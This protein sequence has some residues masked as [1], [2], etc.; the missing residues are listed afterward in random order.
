MKKPGL[1]ITFEGIEGVGKSTQL[2]LAAQWLRERGLPVR[3]T[4]EPGG[5]AAGEA[6]RAILLD[7]RT[8]ALCPRAELLMIFAA[9]A[10]HLDKVV[11]PA[12]AAG[13]LVLCDRFTDATYAYQGGGRGL[14]PA[15]IATLETLVQ[16]SLRPDVTLLLDAPPELG[17]ARS[18]RR[19]DADR[20]EGE[21]LA[22]FSAVRACYL[23]R[24][25]AEPGRFRLIDAS[26]PLDRVSA[27]V[28]EALQAAVEALA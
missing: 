3:L 8:G 23:A 16:G 28:Q 25:R 27:A 14:E 9:R 15:A 22:F 1:F 10:E 17:L 20:F 18:R 7:P 2:E 24:A 11:R 21:S 12:L 19:S 4:R 5:T 13:Q 26:A 6:I